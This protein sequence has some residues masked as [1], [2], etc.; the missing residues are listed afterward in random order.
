M[1]KSLFVLLAF[2]TSFAASAQEFPLPARPVIITDEIAKINADLSKQN[3]TMIDKHDA[4]SKLARLYHLQGD[5]EKSALLWEKAAFAVPEKRDDIALLENAACL[6][7]MGEF[8]KANASARLVIQ[9]SAPSSRNFFK[10]KYLL[11]QIDAFKSGNFEI[12]NTYID[13][14]DYRS[15][16]PALYY[17]LWKITNNDEYK[18]KLIQ[19]YPSSPETRTLFV[20]SG[21]VET[22]QAYPAAHWLLFPGRQDE[23]ITPLATAPVDVKIGDLESATMTIL[24]TGI[25]N[26]KEN[27]AVQ[28]EKVREAG[29][30]ANV[31]K[32]NIGGSDYWSVAVP[33]GNNMN[34]TISNLRSAGF[35]S[36]PVF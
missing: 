17:T 16:R 32:R 23:R 8:D 13:N 11:A 5:L 30:S 4:W 18:A 34:I 3:I 14:P 19:E 22:V 1:K 33:A 26:S 28:A 36:F 27:A 35:D 31:I 29:F 12:L 7:A 20:D 6:M 24:Q 9:T 21:V 10:A 15:E 25:F 2:A